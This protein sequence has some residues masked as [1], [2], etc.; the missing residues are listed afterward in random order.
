M[1]NFKQLINKPTRIAQGSST[2]IDLLFSNEPQNITVTNTFPMSFSDHEL[3]GVVR[4]INNVK[5]R[6]KTIKVRN[7]CNYDSIKMNLE[8]TDW[9]SVYAVR[10]VNKAWE[11]IKSTMLSVFNKHAPLSSKRVRG[12]ITP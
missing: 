10:D 2:L 5:S 12:A 6:P 9:S 11:A 4:K 3:I 1:F 8:N 7:Y